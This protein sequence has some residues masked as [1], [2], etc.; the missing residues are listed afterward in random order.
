M[1]DYLPNPGAPSEGSSLSSGLSDYDALRATE[2][3]RQ[4][5]LA[6]VQASAIREIDS[7]KNAALTLGVQFPFL[8][9]Q[10]Q[11]II[12]LAEDSKISL[13]QTLGPQIAAESQSQG[14]AL[15]GQMG[16]GSPGAYPSG[17][18]SLP[19]E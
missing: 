9:E 19:L 1:P 7:L 12:G 14:S 8:G 11:A 2:P 17:L 13:L 6:G 3:S 10:L 4:P 18:S 16:A 5:S 15:T